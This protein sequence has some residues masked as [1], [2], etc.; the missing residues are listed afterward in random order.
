MHT[1]NNS[2]NHFIALSNVG[3]A[4]AKSFI[5]IKKKDILLNPRNYADKKKLVVDFLKRN[6]YDNIEDDVSK[7]EIKDDE[8]FEESETEEPLE[9]HDIFEINEDEKQKSNKKLIQKESHTPFHKI[10][11]EA[12]KFHD[13]NMKKKRKK[14]LFF[15]PNCTKYFPKK[16]F[17]WPRAPTCLKWDSKKKK[18]PLHENIIN[19]Q[20]LEHE[21]PLK[22]IKNCFINM[23]KQTM[24][25][26]NVKHHNV[27]IQTAKPFRKNYSYHK[28]KFDKRKTKRIKT[29]VRRNFNKNNNLV[30]KYNE[31]RNDDYNTKKDIIQITTQY[32]DTNHNLNI[33]TFS[34]KTES[35]FLDIGEE[36]KNNYYNQ[37]ESKNNKEINNDYSSDSEDSFHK[38]KSHYMKQFKPN[39]NTEENIDIN[40][41]INDKINNSKIGDNYN[42][43]MAKTEIGDI[44]NIDKKKAKINLEKNK[45]KGPEFDKNIPREYYENLKDNGITLIP[46]AANNY[47][48]VRERALSMVNYDRKKCFKRKLDF[49]KGIEVG[50]FMN[51]PMNYIEHKTYIPKFN[52]MHTRPSDENPLPIFMKG[53]VSRNICDMISNVSLK[54]NSF[55]KGKTRGNYDTFMRKKSFNK[56]VNL[57]LMNAQELKTFLAI[58]KNKLSGCE[59]IIKSLRFYNKNYRELLKETNTNFDNITL[60]TIKNKYDYI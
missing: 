28:T 17:V 60:K 41:N 56:I 7:E 26:D 39:G 54:M 16:D 8:N 36:E 51:T 43:P 20:L 23:D 5:N 32:S 38:Y 1:K 24:R 9:E 35:N 53:V 22:N 30:Y 19:Y 27:R 52:K 40:N 42:Y 55:S 47:S 29:G 4:T 6:K 18:K 37:T 49:F 31:T 14:N 58:N 45:I 44:I 10:N 46:F 13:M 15:T 57:N 33:N 59:D 25:G 11:S 21:D 48:Q 12:Y 2:K 50:Q 34:N 3:K